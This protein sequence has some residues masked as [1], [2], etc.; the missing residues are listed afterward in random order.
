M[1]RLAQP[2]ARRAPIEIVLPIEG[3]TCASC[4]NRIERFL[5]K[6][7]GVVQASVNLATERA[8]VTVDPAVAGRSELVAAVEAAGYDVRPE[9]QTTSVLEADPEEPVRARERRTLLIQA[10]A[11]IAVAA[12][13]MVVMFWPQASVPMTTLNWLALVPASV[14]QLWAGRRFY[15]AA[16]RAARH[17]A[18]NMDTL[19]AAGTSAAWAYSVIVT[20]APGLVESAGH[21]PVTYFDSSTIIIGLVLL[22]RWLEAR[23]KDQTGGA[24]RRLIG[25]QP[26]TAHLVEHG[27]DVDVPLA[28]IRVGDLL[29]VRPGE[30]VPVD[31]VVVEGHTAVDES[32]L[33]GEPWQVEKSAGDELVGATLNASGSVV[34]RATRVGQDTVLASIIELVQRAQGS[35]APIERLVDR[36]SEVFVPLVL[37]VAALTFAIWFSAGPEPR[38]TLALT[39]FVAVV[40][41]ACP[42]ALGLATPTAI[43]V[44]TGR[45]AEAGILLRSAEAL[46]QAARVN[47]VVFDKTG[48]LTLGHPTVEEAVIEAGF[49][50]P[51]VVDLAASLERGSEHPLAGA[52]VAYGQ[53]DELGFRA[54]NGFASRSGLGVSGRVDDRPV[55]VGSRR[56]LVELGIPAPADAVDPVGRTSVLVAIDGRLAG[57]LFISDPIRPDASRAVADLRTAGIDVWLV[58]GDDPTAAAVVGEALGIAADHV[59][60]GMLPA[61]KVRIVREIQ[62]GGRIAA[63]VGDGINDAPA[64]AQAD[65]GVAIGSGSDVA[66]EASGLTLVGGN[67]RL[68]PAALSL[69]RQTRAVI[70][71]NLLWA[72]AYNLVLI[73]VAM[74]ALFPAFG[75]LL[76]PA[77]AA[78]AMALSS[79]S[80]VSNSLRLRRTSIMPGRL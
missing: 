62:A 8:T 58:S 38:T 29:R 68:V 51:E 76:N 10:A 25:L 67:P 65:L 79:V 50:R 78:G 2:T 49:E 55:I 80:V 53:L 22:G 28:A 52:I 72:F 75:I 14:I 18:T 35:K 30:K 37:I 46:E 56:L 69:S 54:T 9:A 1:E 71:Q 4:V 73:P 66:L 42:C 39:S 32:M 23:A 61:D 17:G 16:F 21:E 20:L 47:T 60:G 45:A 31:G 57:T 6:T 13:L 26:R 7:A 27:R 36:I 19:V 15:V 5:N 11:S 77:I 34:M 33:T 24:I 64:L 3:M 70:R 44:G 48:T 12:V 74:G 63:M 41:I 59:R 43:I 40:V